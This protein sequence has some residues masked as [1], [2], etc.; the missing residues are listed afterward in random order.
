MSTT[1]ELDAACQTYREL[2]IEAKMRALSIN[3]LANDQRGIPSPLV[4]EYGVLQIR[5]LCEIIALGCLVAHGDLV[6]KSSRNLKT[7]YEP[8]EIFAELDK[9]H[10]DFFPVPI[11]PEKTV[12]GWHMAEYTGAPY[13]TKS[14]IRQIWARCGDVLHRGTL[15]RLIKP[16]NPVQ[17]NFADLNEWGQKLLNLLSNHRII[18]FDRNTAFIALLGHGEDVQVVIGASVSS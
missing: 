12:I 10:G 4:R 18:S 16:K 9:L 8:G 17:N 3:T 14:E 2:M 15:K 7:I 11:M 6:K 13:A 5:M 1:K